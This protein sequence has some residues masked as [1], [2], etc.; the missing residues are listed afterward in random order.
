VQHR[1]N[2]LVELEPKV[3]AQLL[4]DSRLHG[5]ED[6]L[7]HAEASGVLLVVALSLVDASAHEARVPAVH[8]PADDVGLGVVADHVDVG[9]Q[10][11]VI[12]DLLHP[13]GDDFVGVL[14]RGELGLA[15]DDALEV[16]A[17]ER[18]VHG[19]EADAE[20]S[21]RHAREGVLRGAQQVAL[22]EVD[23]DALA[24]GV[25]GHG[26][27]PPVLA[28]EKVHDDLH[29]GRVVAAVGEDHDGVDVRLGEVAGARRL[30][31]LLGE[32]AVRSDGRVPRD[33]V[34]GHDNVLEAVFF[35]NF[36]A[37]VAF[38]ADDQDGLVVLGQ[39]T[40]GRVGLDELVG[41]NG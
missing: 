25:L 15:V 19:L 34:V 7:E 20:G 26:A 31:L 17:R 6:V 40:H 11:L 24:D 4:L 8:V 29:V 3:L 30:A 10:L 36:A 27:E 39:S 2:R 22:R 12:V 37:L 9:G 5:V 28:A 23:G 33:D 38:A 14:V 16:D 1:V 13:A 35:G 41:G 21:L 18:L 32:D